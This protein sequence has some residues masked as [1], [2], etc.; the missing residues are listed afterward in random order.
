MLQQQ[1]WPNSLLQ[2][3]LM[4]GG[5]VDLETIRNRLMEDILRGIVG[6]GGSR[7]E[8]YSIYLLCVMHMIPC[9]KDANRHGAIMLRCSVAHGIRA[10]CQYVG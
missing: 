7:L 6:D 1:N 3:Q 8:P 10:H 2:I 5:N 9:S 4:L